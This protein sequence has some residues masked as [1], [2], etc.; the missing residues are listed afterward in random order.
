MAYGMNVKKNFIAGG[1]ED[2]NS[3]IFYSDEKK[4]QQVELCALDE[5]IGKRPVTL[6]R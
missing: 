3:I 5:V 2:V 6:R 4:D 1:K